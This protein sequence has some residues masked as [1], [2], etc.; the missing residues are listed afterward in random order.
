MVAIVATYFAFEAQRLSRKSAVGRM[1]LMY[2]PTNFLFLVLF[3][4][5]MP[6]YVAGDRLGI[7]A[8][9]GRIKATAL[10]VQGGLLIGPGLFWI[11]SIA[12]YVAV[13]AG[14]ALLPG[15]DWSSWPLLPVVWLLQAFFSLFGL[16]STTLAVLVLCNAYRK[17]ATEWLLATARGEGR[18]T[19]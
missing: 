8:T 17:T 11:A 18:K 1:V 7:G 19:A 6:A 10:P 9:F 13:I 12:V 16:F 14:L 15:A 2:L 4:T 5:A 3:G